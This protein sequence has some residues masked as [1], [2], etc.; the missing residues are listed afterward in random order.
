M[1]FQTDA[2][3]VN[4]AVQFAEGSRDLP[5]AKQAKNQH[6]SKGCEIKIK[7]NTKLKMHL[8]SKVMQKELRWWRAKSI[9]IVGTAV[10]SREGSQAEAS[11][12]CARGKTCRILKI[13]ILRSLL[14][15][16]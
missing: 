6:I 7:K 11:V 12:L 13:S 1:H 2:S 5:G 15:Q 14:C 9:N 8:P 16:H 10:K 4:P 3:P